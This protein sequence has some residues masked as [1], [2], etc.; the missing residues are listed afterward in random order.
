MEFTIEKSCGGADHF[1][2]G[3][4]GFVTEH[5][6][7]EWDTKSGPNAAGW[8][9]HAEEGSRECGNILGPFSSREAA[10]QS[11]FVSSI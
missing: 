10:E 9:A 3:N 5:E 2:F 1:A 7:G 11:L 6:R 8:Y 4:L